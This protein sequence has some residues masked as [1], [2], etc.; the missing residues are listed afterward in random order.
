MGLFVSLP[1]KRQDLLRSEPRWAR[2]RKASYGRS[3]CA[4]AM[5]VRSRAVAKSRVRN[6]TL[7]S[8]T[9]FTR[10]MS[11]GPSA[12]SLGVGQKQY[13]PLR[14]LGHPLLPASQ[15]KAIKS[16]DAV[17]GRLVRST[18]VATP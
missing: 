11:R 6:E 16:L 2:W 14:G 15:T 5:P 13:L 10:T 4:V 12:C 9:S 3:N 17:V 8:V 1:R 18:I 7:T